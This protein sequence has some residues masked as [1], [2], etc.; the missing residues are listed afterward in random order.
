MDVSMACVGIVV[1][2][3]GVVHA[4]PYD[5]ITCAMASADS[6]SASLSMPDVATV[7]AR[8]LAGAFALPLRVDATPEMVRAPGEPRAYRFGIHQG[9]DFYGVAKGTEV[10]AIADGIVV[11]ADHDHSALAEAYRRAMLD[12]CRD[13]RGTPGEAGVPRDP[14]YGD[15]L[16]HLRGRQVWVYHGRNQASEPVLSI[17]AHLSG[18]GDVDVGEFVSSED[19]IGRVGNSGTSQ[20]GVSDTEEM[21]LHL[22][23]YVGEEYWS[24]REPSEAGKALGDE[25][26]A[27]LRRA[28]LVALQRAEG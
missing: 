15:V 8:D 24:P 10:H 14:D 19:V 7:T 20:E 13:V 25:R 21:H 18:I 6:E 28:T 22:E 12:R 17:Y 23:I 1:L 16:D 3:A 9:I 26:N 5:H 4:S 11:R 2:V 27:K